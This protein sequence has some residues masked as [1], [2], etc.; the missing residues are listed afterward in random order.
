MWADPTTLRTPV[1]A[2]EKPHAPLMGGVDGGVV[3]AVGD[4]NGGKIVPPSLEAVGM[5]VEKTSAKK[6]IQPSDKHV[7]GDM[8]GR[9]HVECGRMLSDRGLRAFVMLAAMAV[10]PNVS[11][12]P[13]FVIILV[14]PAVAGQGWL[15]T[16]C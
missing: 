12:T 16:L 11:R 2:A 10:I 15:D 5:V 4:D 9:I 6:L 13:S 8:Q 3:A 7:L 1:G 14:V